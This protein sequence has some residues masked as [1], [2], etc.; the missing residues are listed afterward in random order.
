VPLAEKGT[1]RK[2][3]LFS[4]SLFI[5]IG[6]F[7]IPEK[8]TSRKAPQRPFRERQTVKAS[9]CVSTIEAY[10]KRDL[11]RGLN[12]LKG[13]KSLSERVPFSRCLS[14]QTRVANCKLFITLVYRDEKSTLFITSFHN[15]F[16]NSLEKRPMSM[17]R[18]E[19][20]GR[21]R[22]LGKRELQTVCQKTCVYEK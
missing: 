14:R 7:S 9:F 2:S 13:R 21:E 1:S 12:S 5:D 4:T 22:H 19:I 11:K 3:L 18:D 20:L 10:M 8:G 6:L 15:S 16:R 17:K